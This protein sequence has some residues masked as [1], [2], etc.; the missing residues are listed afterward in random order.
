MG[1]FDAWDPRGGP[2]K[3]FAERVVAAATRPDSRAT[4]ASPRS[5]RA[6]RI[7]A[8]I[9]LVAAAAAVALTV[10]PSRAPRGAATGEASAVERRI[11]VTV[12]GRAV[13]VLEPGAHVTWSG[14]DVVQSSGDVFYRV[15]PRPDGAPFRVHTSAGDVTVL[16]TCFRVKVNDM[17]R[18]DVMSGTAGA[19]LGALALV[20]VY[21]LSLIHI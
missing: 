20:A 8:T 19:A 4:G 13:A 7:G 3:G 6:V 5:A 1:E 15:E 18:R 9:A 17:N 16:G 12:S 10:M 11:E 21:E 2:P 14:S